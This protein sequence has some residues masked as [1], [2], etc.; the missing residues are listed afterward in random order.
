MQWRRALVEGPHGLAWAVAWSFMIGATLFAVGSFPAYAQ[1]VDPRAVG[2][3]FVVGSLFFTAAAY[4]QFVQTVSDD[5]PRLR[6]FGWQPRRREWWAAVIQLVG[7]VLFN[8]NTINALVTGL[9]T[10]EVDRL[11]WAPDMFGSICF[12]VASHLAWL[13]VCGRLWRV[14]TDRADWWAAALNYVG[15]I[16]FMLS[17]IASLVLP[18]TGEDL[19]TAVVNS[20]TCLGALCFLVGAYVLL[21]E[22]EP[23][24]APAEA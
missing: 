24:G 16:F 3:T 11:V 20:G 18:T 10:R 12:L 2:A 9:T 21:P 8:V 14:E 1:L 13:V 4:G 17:A 19:N 15:S 7:T 22:A 23:Q 6:P 5:A